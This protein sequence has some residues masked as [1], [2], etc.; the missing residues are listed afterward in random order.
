MSA[1]VKRPWG[2]YNIIAK[3]KDFLIKRIKVNP[4]GV[5]S[6]QSHNYRSEHWVIIEGKATVIINNRTFYKSENEH[7]HIP[8]KAKHRVLNE[9]IKK[10]LVI[11]EVQTGSKFLESDI[12]RYSDIYGRGK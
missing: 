6:Y 7:I 4:E 3:S 5:L 9:S 10:K 1:I 2:S 12:K 8:K 11:I